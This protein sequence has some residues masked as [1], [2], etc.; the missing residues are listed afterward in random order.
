MIS[1]ISSLINKFIPLMPWKM[2]LQ[3]NN[4]CSEPTIYPGPEYLHKHA[5]RD[6]GIFHDCPMVSYIPIFFAISKSCWIE[7]VPVGE[8]VVKVA[9]LQLVLTRRWG[10]L[11]RPSFSSCGGLQPRPFFALRANKGLFISVLAQ[12]LVFFGDH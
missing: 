12:I 7:V 2:Y 4:I 9:A 10:P 5:C 11:R 3:Q 1:T 8:T 6:H